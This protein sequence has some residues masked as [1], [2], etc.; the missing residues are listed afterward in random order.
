MNIKKTTIT[1]LAGLAVLGASLSAN[2]LNYSYTGNLAQD[3]SVQLFNF[4]VGASSPNVILET[5]SYAGGV[6]A[7]GQTIARGGF[8][9]TLVVFDSA[10]ALI[11]QND[12]G[13]SAFRTVDLGGQAWDTYLSLGSLAAG[14]YTVSVMQ[15]DNFA[16]STLAAGFRHDAP[17]DAWFRNHFVDVS[18]DNYSQRDSHWAFD[19][20]NVESA[21]QTN[22]VPDAGTT[23]TLFGMAL[24][25][26]ALV[27]SRMRK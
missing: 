11:D 7:A 14:T 2:A 27:R 19:I 23:V 26:M 9:P 20:L 1:A 16:L 6:N 22:N 5:W 17:A 18:G 24:S 21:R 12:D 3:N 25:G 8:D 4:T 10:G 13:G 15:Y